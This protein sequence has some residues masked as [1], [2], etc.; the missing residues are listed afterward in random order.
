MR[1]SRL[2]QA[3]FLA[4]TTILLT[5]CGNDTDSTTTMLPDV[6]PPLLTL[7]GNFA[8]GHTAI[9]SVSIAGT[10]ED[11]GGVASVTYQ[12]NDEA[13]RDIPLDNTGHFTDQIFLKAGSNK[14][15]LTAADDAG[16]LLNISKTL[17]LGDK[18][19]AGNSHTGALKEGR[20]YSWGRNNSGQSGIGI[21]TSRVLD[22]ALNPQHPN[23]PTLVNTAQTKFASL[24][25]NQN[26]SLAIAEDGRVY[27]WGDDRFG[28]LGRGALGH[29]SCVRTD[30]CILDIGA[31]DNID[32]AV[33]IA[34]G[35]K[36]NLVL[37]EDG[38][39]WAFGKNSTGQL[40]DGTTDSSNVPVQVDFSAANN[41]GRI[42][43]VVAS[44]D[45]AYAL[46]DKGQVWG[47]GTDDYANLGRGAA[48][49]ISEGCDNVTAT[50]VRIPVIAPMTDNLAHQANIDTTNTNDEKVIQIAAGRDHVLALTNHNS[51]YGWGLNA[52]SQVGYGTT[53][54]T[55]SNTVWDST[56][57]LPT[58]LPWFE[59]KE[60]QQIYANGN[61]SYA[62]LTNGKLYPWGMFGETNSA[63]KTV[64][65]DLDEPTD[66]LPNL[67][68]IDNI[69]MGA[70]HF[71]AQDHNEQ[72]YTWGWSFEG[73]LGSQDTA[74]IWMYNTPVPISLPSPAAAQ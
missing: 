18:I 23:T 21:A 10:A 2:T 50:P 33:M 22:N 49:K 58:K 25:F 32:N 52:Q 53:P 13:P 26:H 4:T 72:L 45:S 34:T 59:D 38:T 62:L 65:Q 39:V 17:Y 43:Q 70:L 24:S 73:S 48:C 5:A 57:T 8:S 63:G 35:Y 12:L 61:T 54:S 27:S 6:T 28:Q 66:K 11:D 74:N 60:V 46:D 31:I 40:G 42:I 69:A 37:T 55:G 1:V 7:D 51:V 64:Y 36:H 30:D 19:A 71:I 56:V 9:S 14:I 29:S 3:L 44:S 67:V 68:N 16:N 47:W 15:T 41:A 20:L